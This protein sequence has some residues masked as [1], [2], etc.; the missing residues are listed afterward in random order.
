VRSLLL[1]LLFLLGALVITT[2]FY[3]TVTRIE[4]S[5]NEHY[6]D[7]QLLTLAHLSPGTPLLWVNT[8]SLR[9]LALDPWIARARLIRHWPDTISLMV[10]ERRPAASDGETSWALDGTVLVGVSASERE[11]LIRLRGWGPPR[12]EEAL[13]LATLLEE[14]EPKVISYTPEGF[15]IQLSETLLFTPSVEALKNHWAAFRGQRGKRVAVYPWGVSI[16]N[17]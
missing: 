2:R 13:A 5:G 16:A 4:V 12:T 10:W 8:F 6:S 3:P 11:T 15:E 17:D 9:K 7:E 14:Y 1:L